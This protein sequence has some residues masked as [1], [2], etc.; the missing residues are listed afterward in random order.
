MAI[1]ICILL[2]FF[3][4]MCINSQHFPHYSKYSATHFINSTWQ[5]TNNF[6]KNKCEEY[7][8]ILFLTAQPNFKI[9][10]FQCY[11][12][13]WK[14]ERWKLLIQTCMKRMQFQPSKRA[15]I[16]IIWTQFTATL[17]DRQAS[18]NSGHWEEYIMIIQAS[19]DDCIR[20]TKC[21]TEKSLLS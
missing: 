1:N 13:K 19:N 17:T 12:P 18:K 14:F 3:G 5:I 15:V 9:K 4:W 2:H 6:L 20:Y 7:T 11:I 21:A 10:L 16:W 8:L